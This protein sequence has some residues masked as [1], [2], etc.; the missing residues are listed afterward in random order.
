MG[1]CGSGY[2]KMSVQAQQIVAAH[3]MNRKRTNRGGTRVGSEQAIGVC[4]DQGEE[5]EE[6]R[7]LSQYE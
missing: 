6:G 4:G 3:K 7:K 2:A 1:V 5:E